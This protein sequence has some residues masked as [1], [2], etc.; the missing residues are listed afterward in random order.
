MK[1]IALVFAVAFALAAP[2]LR[3]A[4]SITYE[5][6]KPGPGKGKHVVLLA[7]DEEYRSE[8]G[9]PMLAKILSQKHGFTT[10]VCFSLGADGTIDPTAAASLSN[11]E[12]LDKADAI[13]MLLRFRKYPDAIM[14]KFDAAVKRGIPIIGLRTST[15]AFN[16][17]KGKYES[18]NNF[19]K[20]VL[21]E[22]WVSHWG[23][24]KKEATRGVIEQGRTDDPLLRG[25]IDVFGDSDVYE[26][27]PPADAKILMRGR[28]LKGMNPVDVGADYK[29]K[30]ST[31][32]VE[33]PV[34][35]PM[36]PIAWT[37]ELPV[38]GGEKKQNIFCTTMGAATDLESEGL[39][40]LV[41]N[42]VYW[43]LGM[44]VPKKADVDL[45]DDYHPTKYGFK[46]F[47]V[48]LKPDDFALGK[49]LPV[50]G[51]GAGLQTPPEVQKASAR[52][53]PA[54]ALPLELVKSERIAL[55]GNSTAERMNLFGNFETS[56]H[57]RH[58]QLQLVFRNFARP[59]DEVALRQRASDYTKIDD[60]LKVF[61]PET[62]LC[63]FGFNE[64]FAGKLGVEK[65][66]ADYEKFLDEYAATYARDNAGSKPRFVIVGPMAFEASGDPLM[67]VGKTENENLAL[68]AEACR[69]V[70]QKRGL[71]YVDLYTQTAQSFAAE[72]GLQFTINGA[73]TN[74]AG[75]ALLAEILDAQLFGSGNPANVNEAL[76]KQVQAEVNEKS[77][78][79]L[80]DYRMING[81][82]VYGGRRTWD[83]ETFPREYVKLRNMAA[84]HDGRIWDLAA[85][86]Q[87]AG[88][89]D[90]SKT[91][92]L[93]VPP[94]RFGEPRQAYSENP[95]GGPV[96]LP[97]DEMIKTVT[98][99]PGFEMKLFADETR[100]PE[101]AKPVQMTFD[102][103]GRL[104]VST[105]PSYPQW[106]PG[107]PRP[108]DKL[109]ILEDADGDGS[110]DKSTVFYDKLHCPTGFEFFNGG[111]LVV[112]QPRMLWLKDTD[113]DDK[114]DVEVS[115]LDGWATEDTHHTIGAWESGPGG[116]IHMLEG[117]AMS[118]AIETPWGA[119]R[120]FGSSGCYVLDPRTWKVRHFKTPGY[121]NPWCYVFNE[122]GQGICGDGT[123]AN[124]HW[125]TP[126]SSAAYPGRKG[127][128][129]VFP[130][131]GMRPV[132]GS[133]YLVSRQFPDD[134]QGQFIYA[135]VI[136][137][138]GMPR[139]TISDDGAGYKGVRVRHNPD[140]AK[141]PYDLL[142]STDKHFRPVDP[143]IGPDGALW[144]GD[145]ANPLIGHMQYSQRDPNRD[146]VHGR[147]YRL[148]YKDKPLVTPVTQ[149]GK[150]NEELFEQFREYEWRTRA[151]ARRELQSR[152]QA[153]V[154]AA[155]KSWVAKLSPSDEAYDRLR[156]EAL[157][158][159]QS[160]HAVDAE[161]L[162]QVL[163]AKR[164]EARAA[165]TR[166][167]TEERDF[168]PEA[169][170]L[171]QAAAVDE[172]PRVAVEAVR[173]LSFFSTTPS[174]AAVL[175]GLA[176]HSG[177]T[178]M[179]YTADAALGATLNGWRGGMLKGELAA[180]DPVAKKVLD[181]VIA[182]DKQG[183]QLLPYLQILLGRDQKSEEEKNKAL[184]AL[185][186]MGGGNADNGKVVFRRSCTACHK[187]FN[188][189]A[190]F[191][192]DMMKVGTR[193]KPFKILQ[194][195]IDPN[196]D[197][198]PKYL[199][200]QIITDEGLTISGLLVSETPEAVVIFDGKEKKTIPT[201]SIEERNKLKQSSMPEGLAS[202]LSPVELL[203]LLAF[204]KSL[205]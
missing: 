192:P 7:G 167:L 13:L 103:K 155:L 62:F 138:N 150:T 26:A 113:G 109:V 36:M 154:L 94:T 168:L 114:A 21:G 3:A 140:D 171:L 124:Q 119:F 158:L 73:H 117:V 152:P 146:H 80:Q 157:W 121:G 31:D 202:T 86:K 169:F 1:R 100:F 17:L 149:H 132:V 139:W 127:M 27:H 182:T 108:S 25:V 125:D 63:F 205:K 20:D 189:G 122:W 95:T 76:K 50:P 200:T 39:R 135:C 148:F 102:G 159:Q 156:C 134:V 116:Q 161:L 177:D 126:L 58:P 40:R 129:P 144:F 175:A 180:N 46:G 173:G 79:H 115:V 29:K 120:N 130:T 35:D 165:A 41:V 181:A 14:Q 32:K 98:T 107:D 72:P 170:A 123:G 55:V 23:V 96:I 87:L 82:Y 59:A 33:Q 105:M 179:Q 187:V 99:P 162:K 52:A 164:F 137:M 75:D 30:R 153:E 37:R 203:D 193:L 77:W 66:Q 78:L 61:G 204:L 8:E 4:D 178:Y 188:E 70:A 172:H 136:N 83:T 186:D 131:E 6:K 143:Q 147:I 160:F 198:E 54:S 142:K 11:P 191:G 195:I 67:P 176:K 163:T 89:A 51:D 15:H 56:L 48:G 111:V 197:I 185:S 118:T 151:R 184:T 196:A 81:W 97:P 133:E 74:A 106:R 16:G 71:A 64:S 84:V 42:A 28:V 10:T 60:P 110:A 5:P 93:I 19:G 44:D 85:G 201:K 174:A 65:F 68:Y 145:W 18:Y 92:D 91:G 57:L 2:S 90:Y 45:V 38:A 22:R 128:N 9:L 12:A 194:S 104:W 112:D 69:A 43:G 141:T 88:P 47:R 49:S 34:N 101:I 53:L 166:V 183:A 190:D 199:S 24:H